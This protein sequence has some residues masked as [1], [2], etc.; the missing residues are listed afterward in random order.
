MSR[1]EFH[2]KGIEKTLSDAIN[3]EVVSSTFAACQHDSS[4]HTHSFT[5]PHPLSLT[6]LKELLTMLPDATP[7]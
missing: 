3:I 7:L 2:R 4:I 1:G 6:T 5:E